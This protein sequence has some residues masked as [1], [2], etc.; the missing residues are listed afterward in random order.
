MRTAV[1]PR[2]MTTPAPRYLPRATSHNDIF[3][4]YAPEP[5]AALEQERRIYK[6]DDALEAH[7]DA[8]EDTPTPSK[9][10]DVP[11]VPLSSLGPPTFPAQYP[12][13][14]KCQEKYS[15]ISSCMQASSVFQN[16]TSIFNDPINYIAVIKCACTDTFQAV[17]PQCVD[18][19]QHTDQ[20][21]YLGEC[22]CS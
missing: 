14:V 13:C 17:Y 15:S 2:A 5:A 12:S 10:S 8:E 4:F 6:R 19:F 11:S 18:C 1:A 7:A 22:A 3:T 9:R 21:W 20:C 16:A